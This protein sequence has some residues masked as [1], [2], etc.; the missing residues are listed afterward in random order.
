MP[1]RHW[2]ICVAIKKYG[3]C[4]NVIYYNKRPISICSILKIHPVFAHTLPFLLLSGTVLE[5]SFMSVACCIVKD[6]SVSWMNSE[7]LPFMLR[8]H[9]VPA[10]VTKVG[11]DLPYFHKLAFTLGDTGSSIRHFLKIWTCKDTHDRKCLELL[12]KVTRV[13]GVFWG[14]LVQMCLLVDFFNLK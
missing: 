13:G 10:P 6:A 7:Y 4:S 12:H 9:T 1:D 2:N 8:G 14:A 5:V 3:E 11:K